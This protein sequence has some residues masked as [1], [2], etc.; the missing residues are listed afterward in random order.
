MK[1]MNKKGFT[2]IELLA[3]IVVLA[4]IMVIA[5]Q[6]VNKTIKK[7]R[8]DSFYDSVQ[9]IEKNAKILCAQSDDSSV[10]IGD[11]KEMSDISDSDYELTKGEEEH[12]FE[13]KGKGKFANMTV[14][15]STKSTIEINGNTATV[16]L[17][18]CTFINETE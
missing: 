3:V 7:S 5:T 12:T 10:I 1:K 11:L 15:S 9:M 18:D 6:Q 16:T 4:I 2:L 17:E 14:P 8:G 13:V